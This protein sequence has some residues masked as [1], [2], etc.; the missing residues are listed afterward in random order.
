MSQNNIIEVV[1]STFAKCAS[2][3]FTPGFCNAIHPHGKVNAFRAGCFSVRPQHLSCDFRSMCIVFSGFFAEIKHL[4]EANSRKIAFLRHGSPFAWQK[5]S[6][7]DDSQ[8]KCA[9]DL[10]VSRETFCISCAKPS[11][12]RLAHESSEERLRVKGQKGGEGRKRGGKGKRRVQTEG[13]KGGEGR[14]RGGKGKRRSTR[15]RATY[16]AKTMCR[17][18]SRDR[19]RVKSIYKLLK[20]NK[21]HAQGYIRNTRI[22]RKLCAKCT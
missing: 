15:R 18:L 8:G 14:K 9:L 2:A 7:S 20:L 6:D 21:G 22:L 12:G 3:D 10:Y 16:R 11:C 5:S 13:Q 1:R 19:N 17:S 4:R